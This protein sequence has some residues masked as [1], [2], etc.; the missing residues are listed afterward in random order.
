MVLVLTIT[1]VV[2]STLKVTFAEIG[3]SVLDC[4]PSGL[5]A[6]GNRS[7]L[8]SSFKGNTFS[9]LVFRGVSSGSITTARRGV[10]RVSRISAIL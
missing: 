4:L 8:L 1:L 10:G 5:S 3:C 7:C 2:P 9:F 6:V